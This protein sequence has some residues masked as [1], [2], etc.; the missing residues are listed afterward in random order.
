MNPALLRLAWKSLINRGTS[1]ALT[2]LAVTLSV[3]LFLSVERIQSGVR[4]SFNSTIS[5]TDIIVGARGGAINLLLYSV[6]RL[7]DPTANIGWQSY[8]R[9][10]GAPGVAWAVPISLGDSHRGY[11]V[12]G[13]T[14]EYFDHYRYGRD[15]PLGFAEGER[16]DGTYQAV[17]GSEVARQLG[18]ELGDEILL[19]HGI[20][21]ISFAEHTGHDFTVTGILAP[22]GTPVDRSV[23]VSLESI[24][25]IH[26]GWDTGVAPGARQPREDSGE[27]EP[28]TIT[29]AF[30]GVQSPIR[31]LSLQR[32]IN[33]FPDEALSAVMPGV[34]LTQLWQIVGAGERA[35]RVI[36]LLVLLVGLI[37]ILTA[38]TSGL[39]ER[40][41]EM[42]VLRAT[43]AKPRDIFSLLVLEATSLAAIGAVIGIVVTQ[44][45]VGIV[46]SIVRTRYGMELG[47]MPGLMELYV[48]L[49]VTFAGA[50][51]G[52]L[53][54][55]QAQRNALSDGLTPK[56]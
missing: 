14:P 41:R 49:A 52:M 46:A 4:T 21:E 32:Q 26:V 16:F 38:L 28:E 37:S 27:L 9:I 15:L 36:S 6:F 2:V 7:G 51:A 18:Y 17:L 11:R 22:S 29:A 48:L 35:F 10:A 33:T 8:Q 34:A 50:A 5:G 20:G 3:T 12:V 25:L 56:L 53:P 54:A 13:T 19:S 31:T 23:H 43:G 44:V 42:A 40:R 45:A 55:W 39:N 47:G 1:A 24:E 30:I